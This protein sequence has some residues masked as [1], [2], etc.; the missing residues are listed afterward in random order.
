MKRQPNALR[1]DVAILIKSPAIG[2]FRKLFSVTLFAELLFYMIT[3]STVFVFRQR[4]PDAL[5][6]YKT[7][8]YPSRSCDVRCGFGHLAR[9]YICI[10][11]NPVAD[12]LRSDPDGDTD[13]ILFSQPRYILTKLLNRGQ[14]WGVKSRNR[15]APHREQV[16]TSS[17]LGELQGYRRRRARLRA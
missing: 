3:S 15:G 10:E 2:S 4:E 16:D 8:G 6:P 17:P 14:H 1:T 5:R 12:W 13:S 7:L 11:S 9:L